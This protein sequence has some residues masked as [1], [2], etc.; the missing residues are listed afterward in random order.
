[1]CVWS[2]G[3]SPS[4]PSPCFCSVD[5]GG[6]G[7]GVGD[8]LRGSRTPISVVF[9]PVSLEPRPR[10]CFCLGGAVSSVLF[11]SSSSRRSWRDGWICVVVDCSFSFSLSSVP[12]P[13]FSSS[14]PS[15]SSLVG[16]GFCCCCCCCCCASSALTLAYCF[17][18]LAFVIRS[19]FI[20]IARNIVKDSNISY[21]V[22]SIQRTL[23]SPSSIGKIVRSHAESSSCFLLHSAGIFFSGSF[24]CHCF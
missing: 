19:F 21:L 18:T 20:L 1:M 23:S 4:P 12:L 8:F 13:S 7:G 16:A 2:G 5:V 15:A 10:R 24:A 11:S 6:G 17:F 22:I 3:A 14:C 9:S